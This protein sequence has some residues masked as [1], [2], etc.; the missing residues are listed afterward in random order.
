MKKSQRVLLGLLL[1]ILM[2][3]AAACAKS[4]ENIYQAAIKALDEETFF[5]VVDIGA[6]QPVLLVTDQVYD[7]GSAHQA[8]IVCDVY[9]WIDGQAQKIGAIQSFGTAYPLAYDD[10]ALYAAGGHLVQQIFVDEAD[11]AIEL[12][13]NTY[14]ETFDEAGESGFFEVEGERVAE[15]DGTDYEAMVE[16]YAQA[17]VIDFSAKQKQ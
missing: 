7:E 10:S 4:E 13:K 3:L 9:Y 2:C 15:I 1:G 8:T 6:T 12:V 14:N 11:D 16:Q 5:A 17:T